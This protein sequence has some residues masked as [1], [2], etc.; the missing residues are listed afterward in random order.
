MAT[1]GEIIICP[2][3]GRHG[4]LQLD[5]FRLKNRRASYSVLH[6]GGVKHGVPR[7]EIE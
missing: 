2:K 4:V 5:A 6:D 7:I 1:L 3:C